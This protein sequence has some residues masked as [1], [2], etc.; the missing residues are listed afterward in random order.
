MRVLIWFTLGCA[1]LAAIAHAAVPRVEEGEIEGAKFKWVRPARWNR[2]ILL[3]AHGYRSES[4]PLIAD[5]NPEH[6]AY[7]KLINE[8]W[9]V[10]KTSYRRNGT[11]L[12]DGIKDIDNLR[13]QIVDTVGRPE[14]VIV[15]GD[16]MGGLIAMLIAERNKEEI[17]LY[18]GVVAVCPA[19]QL[20]DPEGGITGLSMTPQIPIVFLCTRGEVEGPLHYS[21]MNFPNTIRPAVPYVMYV[22]REGHVNVNQAERL[23]ALRTLNLY[24]SNGLETLPKP[25]E[26]TGYVDAT[27]VPEPQPSRVFFDNDKRG[28]T[29]HVVETTSVFGNVLLDAQPADFDTIGI[30]RN[31]FVRVT[32]REKNYRALFGK[33]FTSVK[34]GDWV[35]FLNADG[36]F[37]LARNG[38]NA[39]K[40]LD[41]QAG[42]IVQIRRY[43]SDPGLDATGGN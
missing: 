14:R 28:F 25:E 32:V 29:A 36:F 5:L 26:G 30:S 34:R 11:V 4:S 19:M 24:L 40:T 21:A 35:I 13:A 10:A 41:V 17:P 27:R 2:G 15:E 22:K 16:S 9:I 38:V 18:H 31:A 42:D 1:A 12:A 23:V 39:V 7:K 43:D 37:W 3:I 6:A 8:G 33:D 20:R